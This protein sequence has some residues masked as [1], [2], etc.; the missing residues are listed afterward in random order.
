MKPA[1]STRGVA[2]TLPLDLIAPVYLG[3]PRKHFDPVKLQELADSIKSKGVLQPVVVRPRVC[4]YVAMKHPLPS[5][6][7]FA[8]AFLSNDGQRELKF[9]MAGENGN[10]AVDWWKENGAIKSFKK[11]ADADKFATDLNARLLP[12]ELIAGERRLRASKM[13]GLIEI[14]ATVRSLDNKSVLEI[15]VL[16]NL[17]RD[18]LDPLEEAQGFDSLIKRHDYTAETLAAKLGKSRAYVYGMLKLCQIPEIAVRALNEGKIT[19]SHAELIA[20]LPN[21]KLRQD[22]AKKV[23]KG[24]RFWQLGGYVTEVLSV[25]DAK[26]LQERSYMVELKGAPFSTTDAKLLPR[27]GACKDCPKLTGNARDLYPDGRADMCTDPQCFESKKKANADRIAAAA[28]GEGLKVLDAKEAKRLFPYGG[29]LAYNS[30]YLDF[31]E[32]C[33]DDPRHRSYK[34]LLSDGIKPV[35]AFDEDGKVHKLVKKTDAVELLKEKGISTRL[36]QT[37]SAYD[38]KC[39]VQ[40]Q[41]RR[42]QEKIRTIAVRRALDKILEK[43]PKTVKLPFLVMAM[44][45]LV[46]SGLPEIFESRNLTGSNRT[47]AKL[48]DSIKTDRDA[49]A[50]AL[51]IIVSRGLKNWVHG[52]YESD[53][54]RKKNAERALKLAGLNLNALLVAAKREIAAKRKRKAAKSKRKR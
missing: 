20:R 7:A 47:L 36:T 23:V 35:L 10:G 16:E 48:A 49:F 37:S 25:R 6:A 51:Q 53:S 18:D 5:S 3:Q 29:N 13:A 24:H 11:Q 42:D 26:A 44:V 17:Q 33:Y 28:R 45:E 54:G 12:Y 14:P 40:E 50:L 31:A 46:D 1:P 9:K 19:K 8:V 41:H 43:P 22:F 4:L 39:R 21:E 30:G 32:E 34:Q 38:A 15:Q 52:W 27:A 2:E